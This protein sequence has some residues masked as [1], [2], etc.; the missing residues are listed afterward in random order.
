MN[1]V[2]T[3]DFVHDRTVNGRPLKWLS[4]VDEYTRECVAL[5][6]DRGVKAEKVI[7]VRR[8]VSSLKLR[9]GGRRPLAPPLL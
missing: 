6:V 2:W 3:W 1:H 8:C 5:E 4:I 9:T 7:D